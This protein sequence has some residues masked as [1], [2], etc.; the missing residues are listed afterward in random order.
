PYVIFH[1]AGAGFVMGAIGG[2]IWQG[3]KGA[4]NAPKGLRLG[5]AAHAIKAQSPTV[6]G[7]FAAWTGLLSAFDCAISSY[8]QKTDV[9]NGVLSGAGAGG[10]LS[11]RGKNELP[12]RAYATDYEHQTHI[13][14]RRT[15]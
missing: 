9:W 7:N 6:A 4:R 5:G 3:I 12:I 11:A 2:G 8:R 14:T 15:S 10:C 1:E 13:F